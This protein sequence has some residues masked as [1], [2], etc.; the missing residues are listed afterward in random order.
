MSSCTV[1]QRSDMRPER[2]SVTAGSLNEPAGL[3]FTW[4]LSPAL[5]TWTARVKNSP[6]PEANFFTLNS[7]VLLYLLANDARCRLGPGSDS[8]T[9]VENHVTTNLSTYLKARATAWLVKVI[10]HVIRR[11]LNEGNGPLYVAFFIILSHSIINV[12]FLFFNLIFV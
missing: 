6:A 8:M 9:Y 2:A 10:T 4:A 12:L 7:I 11:G 5:F 1:K 3:H